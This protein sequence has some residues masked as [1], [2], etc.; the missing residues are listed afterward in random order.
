MTGL[1]LLKEEMLK[2]GASK[3]MVESKTAA[4]V[5][6]ILSEGK[7]Y[8]TREYELVQRET[9]VA[10]R[11]RCAR[12]NEAAYEARVKGDAE[13]VLRE[14]ERKEKKCNELI[15][16]IKEFLAGLNECETAEARDNMRIAQIFVNTANVNTKYDNTAFIIGLASILSGKKLNGITELKKINTKFAERVSL[17]EV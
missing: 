13:R 1:E 6:D 14:A 7:S 16:Y 3:T 10:L 2:R 9:D 4:L 11:E 8:A 12:S 17:G 5:L 15:Q